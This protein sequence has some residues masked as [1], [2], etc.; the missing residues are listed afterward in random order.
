MRTEASRARPHPHRSNES[1]ER[2][3]FLFWQSCVG[4]RQR[5]GDNPTDVVKLMANE[6]RFLANPA[7]ARIRLIRQNF[8]QVF[9]HRNSL[10][11]NRPELDAISFSLYPGDVDQPWNSTSYAAPVVTTDVANR[12]SLRRVGPTREWH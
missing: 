2:R 1:C 7:I 6:V 9:R 10:R 8:R 12:R 11:T 4:E 5:C 3:L